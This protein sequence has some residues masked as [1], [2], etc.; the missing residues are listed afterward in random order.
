MFHMVRRCPKTTPAPVPL[1]RCPRLRIW[2]ILFPV[3]VRVR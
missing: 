3:G 2:C 1:R